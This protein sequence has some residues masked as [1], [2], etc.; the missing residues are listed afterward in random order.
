MSVV[1]N[2]K[3]KW[4]RI[5]VLFVLAYE[6]LG[7]LAGGLLLIAAPDGRYMDLPVSLVRGY[8]DDFLIPGSILIAMGVVSAIAFRLVFRKKQNDWFWLCIALCGWYIWFLTEIIIIHELHWLHIMW[9]VPVLIGIIA[10]MPLV[11]KRNDSVSMRNGLLYCGILSSLW[12]A[13]INIYVPLQYEGYSSSSFTVSELSAINAPTRI[14]WMLLVSP[15]PLLF[16]A[17]GWGV[18]YASGNKRKLK[19][20]AGLIIAYCFFNLYWPPMHMRAT[21]ATGKFFLSDTLHIVWAI[22][23]V[24]LFMLIMGFGA[25]SF[26]K[27]FRYFTIASMVLLFGFGMLTSRLA[28]ALQ[29]NPFAGT[30][31]L[32]RAR[33]PRCW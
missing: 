2:Q 24:L 32:R 16:A 19:I 33:S 15:Y 30:S 10:A 7:G 6:A 29:A 31:A 25:A 20:V 3:I 21:L 18:L 12:Y 23:T 13:A 11:A 5:V 8:F 22:V 27:R 26:G 4:Q 14:L 1:G 28:P 17:F 9:A